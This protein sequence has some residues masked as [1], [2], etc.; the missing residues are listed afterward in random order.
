LEQGIIY[1]GLGDNMALDL[2]REVSTGTYAI[3]K[4]DGADDTLLPI[5]T[6]HDGVL[7]EVVETKLFIRNDDVTEYYEDVTVQPIA[8]TLPDDTI[9]I[10]TGHGIKLNAG[11]TQPTEAEW[12][13]LDYADSI[14]M[15]D[16]GASGLGDVSTYLPFWYRAEVPAGAPADNKENIV[17]RISYTASAV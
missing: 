7:G 16:I 2:Y 11:N 1:L 8:K 17:L 6:T 5:I 10:S 3:Y 14:S 12:D 9:G 13:A 4:L 15:A